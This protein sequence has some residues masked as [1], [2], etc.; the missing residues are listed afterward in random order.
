M[1]RFDNLAQEVSSLAGGNAGAEAGVMS[2]V[3]AVVNNPQTGGL[4]G[5]VQQFHSNGMGGIVNS[6]ISNEA[7]QPISGDQITKVLGQDRMNEI[8][9]KFGMQPDQLS[10]MI[11]QHLPGLIDK[12]TPHGQ[13]N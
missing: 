6:W 8:A 1:S 5:L 7:N 2:H 13:A 3:M 10:G 11:A 12:L 9:S 4:Q